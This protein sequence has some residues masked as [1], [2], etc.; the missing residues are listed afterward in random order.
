ML[1]SDKKT[2]Q[3]IFNLFFCISSTT[4]Q[5]ICTIARVAH[6]PASNTIFLTRTVRRFVTTTLAPTPNEF[7]NV[8]WSGF[9]A[10]RNW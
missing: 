3:S 6:Y 8:A 2:K 1:D 9:F 7:H 5:A 10:H 4:I